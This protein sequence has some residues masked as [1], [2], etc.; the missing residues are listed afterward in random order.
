FWQSNECK[1]GAECTFAHET[2]EL[3]PSPKPCFQFSKTGTCKRGQACRFVHSESMSISGK[4]KRVPQQAASGENLLGVPSPGTGVTSFAPTCN[5]T[6]RQGN[7]L[8]PYP[9]SMM[10]SL[11]YMGP[12]PGLENMGLTT[13]LCT[14]KWLADGDSPRSSFNEIP[15][16]LEHDALAIPKAADPDDQASTTCIST[17]PSNFSEGFPEGI[18]FW[19]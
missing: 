19:L 1:L 17:T 5:H 12:P 14:V 11:P 9:S 15:L 7:L 10:G 18:S 8:S 16:S 3:L 6:P 4:A 2:S 13:G